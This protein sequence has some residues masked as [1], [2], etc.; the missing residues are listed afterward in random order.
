ML[1][2]RGGL[3]CGSDARSRLWVPPERQKE[4]GKAGERVPQTPVSLSSREKRRRVHHVVDVVIA[5]WS[6]RSLAVG[7]QRD[8]PLRF[9]NCLHPSVESRFDG[10]TIPILNNVVNQNADGRDVAYGLPGDTVNL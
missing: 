2:G 10:L 5:K 7:D 3:K 1:L 6:F 4:R 9:H 8:H